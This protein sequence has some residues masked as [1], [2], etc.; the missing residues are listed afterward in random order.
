MSVTD[1]NDHSNRRLYPVW[2]IVSTSVTSTRIAYRASRDD[3]FAKFHRWLAEWRKET[4]YTSLARDKI[5]HPTFKKI[6]GI[7]PLATPWILK[8]IRHRPD[9]LVLALQEIHKNENPVPTSARGKVNEIV[10][11]WL[12]W[13]N[14]NS[15]D[16]D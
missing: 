16:A 9:F 10:N 1:T 2:L 13:A 4:K 12:S 5:G 7:G 3:D 11:A 15:I 8:E 6:I 14:R